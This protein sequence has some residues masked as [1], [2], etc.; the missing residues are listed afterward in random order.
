V[1]YVVVGAG[2]QGFVVVQAGGQLVA[3]AATVDATGRL[4][5]TV[6]GQA[7]A[8]TV[9]NGQLSGT[10]GS[11]PI[12][13]SSDVTAGG[14]RF[15]NISS[16]AQV[17]PTTPANLGF[18]LKGDAPVEVLVRAV[19]PTLTTFGVANAVAAP[20][21]D[22]YSAGVVVAT[23]TRWGTSADPAHIAAGTALAGAF[24][25]AASSGDSVLRLRLN[26]GAYTAAMTAASGSGPGVGL[27]EAYD[28]TAGAAGQRLLNVSTL[29]LAGSGENTLIAGVVVAGTAPKRL[30]VRAVGPSLAPLGLP[31]ILARPV[32]SVYS[33]ATLIAQ[34]TG[35]AGSADALAVTQASAETGAFALT[36]GANDA[37]LLVNVAPGLYTA[38]VTSADGGTGLALIEFYELP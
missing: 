14:Q 2:G 20:R 34:N 22:L 7:L 17:G 21:L 19:G 33:G 12:A 24:P 25:L 31:G 1:S 11:A 4:T 10:L 27:I 23:N 9:A 29:A 8:V 36:A 37:A 26:P 18:V 32:V 13:A 28:L 16:R 6:G 3:A 38:Q 30:L 5:A 15:R 35:L